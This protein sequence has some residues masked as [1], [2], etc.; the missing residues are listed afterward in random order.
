MAFSEK[1][2]KVIIFST[3]LT[4]DLTI[5]DTSGTFGIHHKNASNVNQP[6]T[7]TA[8]NISLNA[9]NNLTLS[10]NL[11]GDIQGIKGQLITF[12][13]ERNSLLSVGTVCFS[14]GDS[15]TS[16]TSF[17]FMVPCNIRLKKICFASA[18][19]TGSSF[20][21]STKVV[22]R[23]QLDGSA[24]S[25]YA[26]CDFA[27]TTHGNTSVKRFCNKFSSSSTSQVD[28]EQSITSQYGISIAWN[29]ITN[30][31]N[32]DNTKFRFTVICETIEDL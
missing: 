29:C 32:D 16:G 26:Y 30:N 20:T 18:P 27:D 1:T 12:S 9:T 28:F 15:A 21:T 5:S 22:F 31:I 14:V 4:R 24:Q 13:G 23:L 25:T 17:G 2:N 19:A 10:G 8:S 7:I 11:V 6:L 3:D